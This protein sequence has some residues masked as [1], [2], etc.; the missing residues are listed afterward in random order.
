MSSQRRR[1]TC[2]ACGKRIKQSEPDLMLE[3]MEGTRP[4]KFFTRLA[5]VRPPERQWGTPPSTG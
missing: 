2:K 5:G 4:T 3:D 1:I